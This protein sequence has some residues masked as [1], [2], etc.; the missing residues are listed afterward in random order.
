GLTASSCFLFTSSRSAPS[1]PTKYQ[2][3]LIPKQEKKGFSSQAKRFPS[4]SD[5]PGPASY[6]CISSTELDTPSFSKKGTTGFSR[7]RLCQ[8]SRK[9]GSIVP[10]PNAYNLQ[11]SLLKSGDFHVGPSRAFR[12]PQAVPPGRPRDPTPAPNQYSVGGPESFSSAAGTSSFLSRSSRHTFSLNRDVPSPGHYDVRH[13]FTQHGSTAVLS[14][15]RSRTQRIP[16]PADHR[17]PGPGA[18]SPHRAWVKR[19]VPRGSFQA[20][21]APPLPVPKDPPSPGPGQY[22]IGVWERP[23]KPPKPNA[24]F[25]SRTERTLENKQAEVLPGPGFYDPQ[26]W[27][28]PSF[29]YNDS[30]IWVP[31]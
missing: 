31:V 20:L 23:S 15:F 16:P 5:S 26:L 14:P 8:A 22:H 12:A 25:A 28:K 4:P 21:W 10:G 19:T 13:S 27:S 2:T 17:V 18:Y 24:A 30:R 29:F 3:V 11:R 7:A 6:S 9:A 1:I